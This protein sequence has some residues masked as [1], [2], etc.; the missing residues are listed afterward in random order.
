MR[1]LPILL[2][3]VCL[4]LGACS[5]LREG[6]IVKKYARTGPPDVYAE[7]FGFRF[8]P[9]VYWVRIE[10]RDAKGRQCARN[11]ILF[12]HDW[13][14]LRVGDHWSRQNGFAPAEAGGK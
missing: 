8:D 10:G 12:R 4:T 11:V 1:I 2:I 7:Q 14:Q 5:S 6:V 3:L 13:A 9:A